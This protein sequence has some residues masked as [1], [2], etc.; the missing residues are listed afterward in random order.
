[1]EE[2]NNEYQEGEGKKKRR[3]LQLIKKYKKK[4]KRIKKRVRATGD[5]RELR[6]ETQFCLNRLMNNKRT[7]RELIRA[8]TRETER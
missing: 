5:L 6:R 8:I 7:I 3:Q 4:K 1:M 2:S